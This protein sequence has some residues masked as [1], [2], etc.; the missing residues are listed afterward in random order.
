MKTTAHYSE[1]M[2]RLAVKN[3][4]LRG[5]EAD[6]GPEHADTFRRALIK[7]DLVDRFGNWGF[8]IATSTERR[9]NLR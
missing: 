8:E 5:I 1:K 2:P 4:A 7:A 3:L 9:D 6:Y